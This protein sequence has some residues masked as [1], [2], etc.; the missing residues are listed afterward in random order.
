MLCYS[1]SLKLDFNYVDYLKEASWLLSPF[2]KTI[3]SNEIADS[4][5]G[6]ED[7]LL[8]HAK[9]TLNYVK[10]IKMD[11]NYFYD[12]SLSI[13]VICRL[14]IVRNKFPMAKA[15]SFNYGSKI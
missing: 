6:K 12:A 10:H 4:D 5:K 15:T 9:S 11:I 8:L 3:L 2:L 14:C 1:H 7:V 13:L